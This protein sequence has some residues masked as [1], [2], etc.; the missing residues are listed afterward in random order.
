MK[1]LL[2]C[3]L[4]APTWAA[5]SCGS[6]FCTVNT[7]WEAHGA[8]TEPGTRLDF[9]YEYINQDQPMAGS[10]KVGVG[11]V[12]R[13]HDEVYTYPRPSLTTLA[14][15]IDAACGVTLLI[16]VVGLAHYHV[17]NPMVV[18]LAER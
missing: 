17:P 3:A 18:P 11:E 12:P 2:L 4:L 14:R 5:A 13:H 7:N 9:R 8:W 6:A 10:R 16:P 15:P 1:R